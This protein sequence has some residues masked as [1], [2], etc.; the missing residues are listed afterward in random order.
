[1]VIAGIIISTAEE[2]ER[3]NRMI[4]A[5]MEVA[6]IIIKIIHKKPTTVEMIITAAEMIITTVETTTTITHTTPAI[7][8]ITIIQT[9]HN[10]NKKKLTI[11]LVYIKFII[12]LIDIFIYVV[13]SS[14]IL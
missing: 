7:T 6:T 1:M 13:Y 2:H 10:S 14:V 3:G 9:K 8:Q 5:I 11:D 4:I 12:L